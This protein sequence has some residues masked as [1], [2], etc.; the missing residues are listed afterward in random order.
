MVCRCFKPQL[1]QHQ[2]VDFALLSQRIQQD[3]QQK[4]SDAATN[5]DFDEDLLD[6]FP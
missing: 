1:Q 4:Q 5:R 2:G 3:H 6:I